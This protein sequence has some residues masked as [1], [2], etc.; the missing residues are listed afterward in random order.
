[1]FRILAAMILCIT[2]FS[3]SSGGGSTGN[4][5]GTTNT[6]LDIVKN[7]ALAQT[8][9]SAYESLY[10]AQNY[11]M[12]LVTGD[13]VTND[14][15]PAALDGTPQNCLDPMANNSGT[16]GINLQDNNG[17]G[18][19]DAGESSTVVFTDCYGTTSNPV[20]GTIVQDLH[21]FDAVIDPATLFPTD[22]TSWNASYTYSNNFQRVDRTSGDSY[23]F[24]GKVNFDY[25][26]AGSGNTLVTLAEN[27]T[28]TMNGKTITM[29]DLSIGH[30]TS[31][32]VNTDELTISGTFSDATSGTIAVTS[33]QLKIENATSDTAS[34]LTGN[35]I[36]MSATS[37]L[38]L[39]F[40]DWNDIDMFLDS[41]NDGIN[42]KTWNYQ[43]GQPTTQGILIGDW[44]V[45]AG[46]TLSVT[47][48]DITGVNGANT[49]QGTYVDDSTTTEYRLLWTITQDTSNTVPLGTTLYCIYEFTD[50]NTA[51]LGCS[52]PGITVYPATP[53][54]PNFS[55]GLTRQ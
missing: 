54:D 22:I 24:D 4:N 33:D 39:H 23:A 31:I 30:D 38:S 17:N 9:M 2:L 21:S 52:D 50:A 32:D 43:P 34:K 46:G 28:A 48:T 51:T 35:L 41:N 40:N 20:N 26:K 7:N 8:F 16:F 37:T 19:I 10:A 25:A 12:F 15:G 45:D 1:M 18:A 11:S 27:L 36:L 42:D 6:D 13:V 29:P 55:L 47:N 3:C 14:T 49:V 53:V 44:N 5:G